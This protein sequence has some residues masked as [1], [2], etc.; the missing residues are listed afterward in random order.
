MGA[1]QQWQLFS[2]SKANLGLSINEQLVFGQPQLVS[3][4]I[5]R[6][7]EAEPDTHLG[8]QNDFRSRQTLG[9]PRQSRGFLD[10]YEKTK[11]RQQTGGKG[12]RDFAG[13]PR[14]YL[15][16]KQADQ[17]CFDVKVIR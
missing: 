7:V 12:E 15:I 5:R 17:R 3:D 10:D 2:R 9:V 6:L 16:I 14:A 1:P 13:K 8:N 11:N 4:A